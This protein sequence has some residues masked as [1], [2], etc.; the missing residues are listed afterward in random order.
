MRPRAFVMV[1]VLIL[2]GT[3]AGA[4]GGLTFEVASVKLNKSGDGRTM[5]QI[6]PGG[7][8]VATNVPL[9][10]LI[11]QAFA[12][13][14]PL[15]N[16]RIIGGPPWLDS[17]RYDIN[18]KAS[19]EFQPG[20]NGPP[21]ALFAML[22]ALLEE[23]FKLKTH[24]ESKELPVYELVVARSDGKLGPQMQKSD[25]DCAA[26]FAARRGGGPPP[27]PPAPGERP[28]CGM[29]GSPGRIQAGAVTMTQL[30]N[31]LAGRV[32]R[33]II[34]K[35]GLMGGFDLE[36]V[37]TPDQIPGPP[38]PGAPPLPPIDPNG[39][40]LFTALQEQLGLKLESG[41]GMVDVLVIDSVEHLTE[42]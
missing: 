10:V 12:N 5:L 15:P 29:F 32:G 7:R 31:N 18:A 2:V 25:V 17:E 24:Y 8:F 40:S 1:G 23:R 41:K 16:F 3:L 38:P 39:P 19:T 30:V 22:R 9:K 4:Q 27:P 37:W 21:T 35:T 28:M 26:L 33:T 20:T 6:P 34:D 36:L 11:S 14:Q 13:P 42:D